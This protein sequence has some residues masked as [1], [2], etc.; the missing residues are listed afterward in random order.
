[1]TQDSMYDADAEARVRGAADQD[2]RALDRARV[3]ACWRR[4]RDRKFGPPA[5]P[6][7]ADTQGE[8]FEET[9]NG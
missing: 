1:M 7:F 3:N 5:G 8:L 6:L 9:P 2:A 4:P